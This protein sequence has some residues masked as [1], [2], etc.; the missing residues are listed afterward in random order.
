MIKWKSTFSHIV[1][2]VAGIRQEEILSPYIFAIFVELQGSSLGC[3]I[4]GMCYNAIMYADD[5]LL[6][7]I[8]LRDLQ[9]MVD[10]CIKE[11]DCL[12]L[13]INIRTSVCMLIGRKHLEKIEQTVISNHSPGMETR[14][15][16]P[17]CLFC[18]SQLI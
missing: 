18:L 13:K 8:S 11:F 10:L 14:N 9:L 12:D 4:A 15:E 1:K 7:A 6:L 17:W 16:I 3:H 5:M 2:L